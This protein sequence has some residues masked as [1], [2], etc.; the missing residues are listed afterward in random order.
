MQK[1]GFYQNENDGLRVKG[2]GLESYTYGDDRQLVA[3]HRS[4]PQVQSHNQWN[5]P[6]LNV[7][8][9]PRHDDD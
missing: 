7:P 9:N 6:I 8:V 1:K 2:Q 4:P 3:L 5:H